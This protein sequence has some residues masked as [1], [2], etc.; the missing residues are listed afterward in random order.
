MLQS[1]KQTRNNHLNSDM[2][3]YPIL[4]LKGVGFVRL[5]QGMPLDE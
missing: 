2:V 3:W 5:K 1:I 4:L